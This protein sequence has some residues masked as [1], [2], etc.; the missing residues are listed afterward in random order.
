M[1][2]RFDS[3][4]LPPSDTC[5][6]HHVGATTVD[7]SAC[8]RGG[9]SS[10]SRDAQG[11]TQ[12]A[13]R[14]VAEAQ[15]TFDRRRKRGHSRHA[16][17]R[18]PAAAAAARSAHTRHR[19]PATTDPLGTAA[20]RSLDARIPGHPDQRRAQRLSPAV[21]SNMGFRHQ[22]PA[23]P[24]LFHATEEGRR[25]YRGGQAEHTATERDRPQLSASGGGAIGH[26]TTHLSYPPVR[27]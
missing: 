26:R 17:P 15:A 2:R 7:E 4:I 5:H 22:L 10:A 21:A 27:P 6:C 1:T 23:L 8:P 11:D 12:Q 16:R 13:I 25:P 3:D 9:C 14:K 20:A 19:G 18:R 24:C